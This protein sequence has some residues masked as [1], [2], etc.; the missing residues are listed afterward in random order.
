MSALMNKQTHTEPLNSLTLQDALIALMVVVSASDEDIKTSELIAIDRIVEFF[1]LFSDY[2]SERISGVSQTVLRHL[3]H[4][5]DLNNL[6]DAIRPALSR[7]YG[8]TAYAFACEI[9]S[10]DGRLGE[11][12]VR[13][14]DEIRREIGVDRL[15][16][17]AI[18]RGT[19]ARHSVEIPSDIRVNNELLQC[20]T[21]EDALIAIMIAV[22][23]SD[24][25]VFG[26]ELQ[27]I[28]HFV[29][30]TPIFTEY[31]VG[32]IATVKKIVVEML[33]EDGGHAGLLEML[34]PVFHENL[35]ETAY[36]FACDIAAADGNIDE[37]EIQ[38]LIDLRNHLDID[39]L[40]SAAIRRTTKA[41]HMA[42]PTV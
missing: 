37:S 41:L 36:A 22:S 12:E 18:E 29:D 19:I 27:A 1:P 5:D 3:E 35:F 26:S 4:D 30:Y 8:E 7:E 39:N 21:P 15:V 34:W 40:G 42:P 23:Y 32:R 33:G 38:F 10:A 13:V 9:A 20:M 6:F 2:D 24:G 11:M 25:K 28:E 17:A 16:G 31:D 14:L